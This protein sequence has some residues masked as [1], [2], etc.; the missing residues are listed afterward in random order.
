MIIILCR[1]ILIHLQ[2]KALDKAD[3]QLRQPWAWGLHLSAPGFC[4]WLE[5][6]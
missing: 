4:L 3:W 5:L 2:L 6:K 1:Q